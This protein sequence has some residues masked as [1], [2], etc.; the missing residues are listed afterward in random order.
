MNIP[1][2]T[3]SRRRALLAIGA[4]CWSGSTS[5]TASAQSRAA[6]LSVAEIVQRNVAARGGAGAWRA[7][8]TLSMSGMMDAGRRSA[9][10]RKLVEETRSA[11]GKPR[12]RLHP[13]LTKAEVQP[14]TVIRLPYLIEFRR[15]RQMRVELKVKD[16]TAIQVYDGKAGWKVRPYVGRHEVEPYSAYELKLAA[17]QQEFDG[18]LIDYAAKG[19]K[20]EAAGTELVDG[21]DAYKLKLTLKTGVV[22]NVW[23]RRADVPRR[24]AVRC[25]LACGATACG[26][27]RHARLPQ[28][29]RPDAAVPAR[30][31]DPGQSDGPAHRHP[32]GGR[33]PAAVGRAVREA[34]LTGTAVAGHRSRKHAWSMERRVDRWC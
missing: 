11:P 13:E 20:V 32:A 27:D 26:R 15:P 4:A 10:A 22:L 3:L 24:E 9:D 1:H 14:D 18:P 8:R 28:G 6:P 7:V 33:Q 31:S 5:L 23:G 16:A 21:R 17:S 34:D 12:R 30:G 25:A 19:T 29:Q 2:G